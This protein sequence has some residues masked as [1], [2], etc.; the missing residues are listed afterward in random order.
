LY[1]SALVMITL[2][3]AVLVTWFVAR[4]APT[5]VADAEMRVVPFTTYAGR[6]ANPDFSPDG[7]RLVFDGNVEDENN[8]D[9]YVQMIDSP[10][11]QRLTTNEAFD[12]SPRFSP[13]GRFIAFL[14]RKDPGLK[15]DLMLIPAIGGPERRIAEIG[16]FDPTS[17]D[18]SFFAWSPDSSSLVVADRSAS[19][20]P[21]SLFVIDVKGGEPRRLTSPL[22]GG[23]GV[24]D[25]SP[26]FSP[27]GRLIAFVRRSQAYIFDIFVLELGED[28]LPL[29]DP[30]QLTFGNEWRG[31]PTWTRDGHDVIYGVYPQGGL[32][33]VPSDGSG[34]P[35]SLAIAG[36][37]AQESTIA[38]VGNRLAFS[39]FTA[40]DDIWRVRLSENGPPGAGSRFIVSSRT[41]NSPQY[42]PDGRRIAFMSNRSGVNG[43]WLCDADG[44]NAMPLFLPTQGMAGTPRWSPDGEYLVF[45]S[46][47]EG[48]WDVY[49][50]QATGGAPLVLTKNRADDYVASWSRD[51]NWVYFASVR[52]GRCEVW[53]KSVGEDETVQV[54]RNGGHGAFESVDGRF[55]YYEKATP[56]GQSLWRVPVAGGTEEKLFDAVWRWNFAVVDDGV[57]FLQ[58]PGAEVLFF[59]IQFLDFASGN[60]KQVTSLEFGVNNPARRPETGFTISPDRQFI[61]YAQRNFTN[62]IML[63]ENFR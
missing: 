1:V 52:T 55:V 9:I 41:E 42:S 37:Q 57:Y 5:E 35:T 4:R 3:V 39:Q 31:S 59:S 10:G 45:D 36:P 18:R 33:R 20:E 34:E 11:F 2:L 27:D 16:P 62:D 63:V 8:N 25:G 28:L 29:G 56:P 44:R 43:I 38:P 49:M 23:P 12:E 6:E 54:T 30:R 48:Q 21:L 46:N 7:T 61:L 22:K 53:K 40:Q 13:D 50:I 58:P 60:A 26:A 19:D 15:C 47:Q 14:R 24:S 17:R 32:W 51:G